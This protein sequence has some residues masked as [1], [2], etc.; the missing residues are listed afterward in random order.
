VIDLHL[1]TT[2]SDGQYRPAEIVRLAAAA[3]LRVVAITDHDTTGGIGEAADAAAASDVTV[4]P[5]IEITAIAGGL[6]LHILGYFFDPRSDVLARLL[7]QQRAAR[8]D[9]IREI[10]HRLE[11]LGMPIDMDGVL[12]QSAEAHQ[13]AIG[14]PAVARALVAAGHVPSLDAAFATLIGA[15]KPAWAPRRG[16]T[17]AQAIA[18]LA[19]AGGIASLA[20]PGV[21]GRDD[22]LPE[23]AASGLAALEVHH[24][25]HSD[26][27]TDHYRRMASD[28]GLATSGGSDFHGPDVR[29]ARSRPGAVTLPRDEYD[30][31]IERAH[32]SSGGGGDRH[33]P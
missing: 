1:H 20:H 33:E 10:G 26:A 13:H 15:G 30:R 6:D 2:A 19:E 11:R 27:D 24:P 31:L 23:L 29:A 32:R 17:P 12:R 4:V 5:G 16:P 3:G 21:L 22:V 28:L 18:V 25:D 14:R 7:R 9:R 8:V